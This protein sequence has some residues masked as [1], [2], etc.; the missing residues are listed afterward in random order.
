MLGIELS[1]KT[2]AGK[3]IGESQ[4]YKIFTDYQHYLNYDADETSTW[5]R[6]AAFLKSV[7]T[8]VQTLQGSIHQAGLLHDL[9]GAIG[10][11]FGF[12]AQTLGTAK[13]S[14]EL[15]QFGAKLVEQ[16]SRANGKMEALTTVLM[17]ALDGAYN[18]VLMVSV[19]PQCLVD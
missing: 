16:L 17:T 1:G 5:K 13:S 4:F 10:N 11:L 6:R 9:R 19:S 2:Q 8:C 12:S 3:G 14:H 18:T 7:E 15:R